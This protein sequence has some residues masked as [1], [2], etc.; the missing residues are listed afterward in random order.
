MQ[1]NYIVNLEYFL[2][3]DEINKIFNCGKQFFKSDIFLK[4]YN[5]L[6]LQFFFKEPLIR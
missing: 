1:T 6:F 2:L 4:F 3:E 5:L